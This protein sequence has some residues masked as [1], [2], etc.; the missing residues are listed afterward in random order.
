MFFFSFCNRTLQR[1]MKN[2][3]SG[4]AIPPPKIAEAFKPP[5]QQQRIQKSP[6]P[7]IAVQKSTNSTNVSANNE[8]METPKSPPPPPAAATHNTIN[9]NAKITTINPNDES[10]Y[11]VTEL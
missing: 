5:Q 1:T 10:N 9:S 3:P 8:K 7:Q 6:E 2:P 4:K 11:A